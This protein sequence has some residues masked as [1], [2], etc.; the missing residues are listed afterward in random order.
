M[1]KPFEILDHTADVAVRASGADLPALFENAARG[2]LGLMYSS[3]GI[4]A[5][6]E[7]VAIVRGADAADLLVTWLH[8]LLYRFDARGRVYADVSVETVEQ[9]RLR[10]RLRGEAFDPARHEALAEIKAVTYH[11]VRVEQEGGRW[12]AE[13]LF[14]I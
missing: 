12:V 3:E 9:W 8:E 2:M 1:C 10:A 13:V 14:D 11:G 4:G 7:E 6:E 5:S